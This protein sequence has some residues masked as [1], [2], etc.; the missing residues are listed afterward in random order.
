MCLAG[1]NN[2]NVVLGC[3]QCYIELAVLQHWD[4]KNGQDLALL[5][6]F[7]ATVSEGPV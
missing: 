1:G 6:F 7:S 3:A 5:A 4:L 2:Q